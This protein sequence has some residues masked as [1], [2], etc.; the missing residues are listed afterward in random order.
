MEYIK[1]MFHGEK[2]D[3]QHSVHEEKDQDFYSAPLNMHIAIRKHY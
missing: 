1:S 2:Y 3:T